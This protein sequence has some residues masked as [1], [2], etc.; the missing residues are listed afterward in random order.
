MEK[1]SLNNIQE[2]YNNPSDDLKY[3]NWNDYISWMNRRIFEQKPSIRDKVNKVEEP[4]KNLKSGGLFTYS[5]I[6]KIKAETDFEKG[7]ESINGPKWNDVY[8]VISIFTE[9]LLKR[10]HPNHSLSVEDIS[11][12]CFTYLYLKGFFAKYDKKKSSKWTWVAFG[13]KNY[14]IDLE[15]KY[16]KE[17]YF[18]RDSE[19]VLK[20]L[21]NDSDPYINLDRKMILF[22]LE[23]I[24]PELAGQI[25]FRT[26]PKFVQIS[27][28]QK[29]MLSEYIVIHLYLAGYNFKTISRFFKVT[30][31]YIS[32]LFER[33]VNQLKSM[34]LSLKLDHDEPFP[35]IYDNKLLKLITTLNK[36]IL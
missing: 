34:N 12:D 9:H 6:K 22:M 5:M 36:R 32:I 31:K 2:W 33:G 8:I 4:K 17:K 18:L 1:K 23:N 27:K 3:S 16:K 7:I 25:K 14:L 21:D 13:V 15:R 29:V 30:P 19:L 20:L 10:F 26:K 24:C 35:Y 11:W 28:T